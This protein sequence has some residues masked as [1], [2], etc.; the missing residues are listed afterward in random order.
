MLTFELTDSRGGPVD[1]ARAVSVM[2]T[3]LAIGAE[4]VLTFRLRSDDW[5]ALSA[6]L[7]G[8]GLKARVVESTS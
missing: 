5:A 2:P 3:L 8:S 1:E 7:E 6:A 4:A